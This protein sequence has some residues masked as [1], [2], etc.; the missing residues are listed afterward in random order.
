MLLLGAPDCPTVPWQCLMP[1]Q[2][3]RI[4]GDRSAFPWPGCEQN[5]PHKASL[6]RH[7]D[8]QLEPQV[9]LTPASRTGS[10]H[11]HSL[12]NL[13]LHPWPWETWQ[14]QDFV[15]QLGQQLDKCSARLNRSTLFTLIKPTFLQSLERVF[16]AGFTV[17]Q[18]LVLPQLGSP[19]PVLTKDRTGNCN[20]GFSASAL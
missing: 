11:L 6:P 7:P 10:P 9:C 8:R 19:L 1:A 17:W 16:Q 13:R 20:P 5:C 15:H 18:V 14:Q 2:P 12:A 3:A 4:W